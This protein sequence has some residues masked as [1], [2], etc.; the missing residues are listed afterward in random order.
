MAGRNGAKT[1]KKKTTRKK[2]PAGEAL[3]EGLAEGSRHK[4]ETY[5]M[6]E[7]AMKDGAEMPPDTMK[8]AIGSAI[9]DMAATQGS[10][11]SRARRFLLAVQKQSVEAAIALDKIER[12]DG[13]QPT[14]IIEVESRIE[15]LARQ[16][17]GDYE[18][19]R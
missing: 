18:D 6:I 8:A 19:D 10:T 4:R 9:R 13:G 16:I 12:L 1:T 7:R 15:K 11:R 3:R 5:M 17:D 14:D 2:A